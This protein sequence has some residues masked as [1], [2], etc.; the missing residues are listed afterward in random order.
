M[1]GERKDKKIMKRGRGTN[2]NETKQSSKCCKENRKSSEGGRT[3]RT[4]QG[5]KER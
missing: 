1:R 3:E 5:M 4:K 2:K